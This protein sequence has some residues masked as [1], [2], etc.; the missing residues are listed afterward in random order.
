MVCVVLTGL[1][2]RKCYEITMMDGK[3][4]KKE[5]FPEPL[6]LTINHSG[7]KSQAIVAL[8]VENVAFWGSTQWKKAL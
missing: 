1:K 8:I 4:V 7:K 6:R 5:G 2:L 3:V